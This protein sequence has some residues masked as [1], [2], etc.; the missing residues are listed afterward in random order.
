[1]A[2]SNKITIL[3]EYSS[4][5]TFEELSQSLE[6]AGWQVRGENLSAVSLI[7]RGWLKFWD[8]IW[9]ELVSSPFVLSSS[10][11]FFNWARKQYVRPR[12]AKVLSGLR[13]FQPPIILATSHAT[14]LTATYMKSRKLYRGKVALA[15]PGYELDWLWVMKEIDLYLCSSE[16]QTNLLKQRQVD[17]SKYIVVRREIN[18]DFFAQRDRQTALTHL[19]LLTTMPVILI[20]SEF[21][22]SE[23]LR[24]TFLKLMRMTQ[25][26]Q[27]AVFIGGNS[28]FKVQV[29]KITA[30]VRH[31]VKIYSHLED[32]SDLLS[33]SVAVLGPLSRQRIAEASAKLVPIIITDPTLTGTQADLRFLLEQNLVALGRIPAESVFLVETVLEGKKVTN[34]KSAQELLA[35][36]KNSLMLPDALATINPSNP[37]VRV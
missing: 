17:S 25:S 9:H 11:T 20:I 14:A 4:A 15:L 19:E 10:E 5:K 28:D 29:E 12:A 32:L 16:R 2:I 30:P 24:E 7:K 35:N 3:Y 22:D 21:S 31:P 18:E 13:E 6:A 33:V 27:V 37:Q 36:P 34:T 8:M 1:M 23:V 26:C